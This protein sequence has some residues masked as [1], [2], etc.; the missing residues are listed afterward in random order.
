MN[1]T[2]K[3]E[4]GTGG[5][6]EH[7]LTADQMAA[8]YRDGYVIVRGFFTAEEIE[9]LRS[10]CLADP[11]IGGKLRAVADSDGHAQEVIGWTDVYKRQRYLS[12]FGDR[13][14]QDNFGHRQKSIELLN[15]TGAIFGW[16]MEAQND[17]RRV[18]VVFNDFCRGF[19]LRRI[20]RHAVPLRSSELLMAHSSYQRNWWSQIF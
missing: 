11:S 12:V 19:F 3:S 20:H 14:V 8:F 13:K 6:T 1:A 7:P 16:Q 17:F 5:K 4:P 15:H 2:V 18:D 9:P 10:A